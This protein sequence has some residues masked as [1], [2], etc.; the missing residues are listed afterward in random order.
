M[1][2]KKLKEFV[3]QGDQAELKGNIDK[4][5][6]KSDAVRRWI[7]ENAVRS[8]ERVVFEN[9]LE[10]SRSCIEIVKSSMNMHISV[11]ALAARSIF[12]I[13]IRVRSL[14]EN[15]EQMANWICEAAMDKIQIFEGIL[16]LGHEPENSEKV[17]CLKDEVIRLK[18]LVVKYDLPKI[19][20]PESS[21]SLAKKFG[22]E[23]EHKALYK[24]FSKL[25]H[26]SSFLV[27][28][29][30]NASSDPIR[31]ILQVHSQLYA[32]ETINRIC[33]TLNVPFDVYKR[34]GEA[35][36]TVFETRE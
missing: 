15:K 6:H 24:L 29:Y 27:N 2:R 18:E 35:M 17:N 34:N 36:E 22:Q 21:G 16:T 14:T 3:R 28:D 7:Q 31:V 25:V 19:K 11:L 30:S 23:A 26:P 20:S 8:E 13:N 1:M 5:T 10:S 12:E 9:L 33:N 32:Q 4:I